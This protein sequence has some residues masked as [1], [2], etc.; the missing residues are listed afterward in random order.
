VAVRRRLAGDAFRVFDLALEFVEPAA[1]ALP[2]ILGPA[3]ELVHLRVEPLAVAA[4][5]LLQELLL[6][7]P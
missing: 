1:Q 4:L 3:V 7:N 5:H 2:P 6:G